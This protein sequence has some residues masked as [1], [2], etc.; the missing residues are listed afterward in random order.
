MGS[1]CAWQSLD[2]EAVVI[3]LTARRVMGLNPAGTLLWSHADG[4]RTVREL[5]ELLAA[6][7]ALTAPTAEADAASFVGKMVARGLMDLRSPTGD[8]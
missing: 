2:G 1:R 7:F 4:K 8:P 6:R 3:D 5:A